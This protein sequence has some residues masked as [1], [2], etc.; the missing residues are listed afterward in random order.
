MTAE[1]R[2]AIYTKISELTNDN[3]EI[4]NMLSQLQQ[5]ADNPPT[6]GYTDADVKDA[7]GVTW[8]EKF[9]QSQKR[10]RDRFFGGANE[11]QPSAEPTPEPEPDE[12][13]EITFDDL[14]K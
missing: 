4:M 7:D 6:S 9:N 12:P 8:K 3:E 14:F 1:E 2:R 11:P 13:E 5:D 10:Y